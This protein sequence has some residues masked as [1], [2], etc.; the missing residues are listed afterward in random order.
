MSVSLLVRDPP[1][2]PAP[3]PLT[4]NG[5]LRL[6]SLLSELAIEETSF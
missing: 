3:N 6:L 4:P 2:R 5:T 1:V